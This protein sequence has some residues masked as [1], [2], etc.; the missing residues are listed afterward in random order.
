MRKGRFLLTQ[1]LEKLGKEEYK[2]YREL[3]LDDVSKVEKDYV[4][5]LEDMEVKLLGENDKK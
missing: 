1:Q 3:Y 4:K 5:A 2:K